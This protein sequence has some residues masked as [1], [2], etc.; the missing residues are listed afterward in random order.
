MAI[1]GSYPGLLLTRCR[2]G[3]DLPMSEMRVPRG[4]RD[5]GPSEMRQRRHLE[6]K[7][8]SGFE[9]FAYQEVQTP[10]FEHLDLFTAK[11]GQGI[12]SELYDFLDKGGRALALRPE[13]TAAVMRFYHESM[14]VEPKPIK[15]FYYGNCFRYDRPQKGRYREF[16]QMGC[17]LIGP[18]TPEAVGEVIALGV[19]LLRSAGVKDLV[20]RV[21]HLEVLNGALAVAGWPSSA[22]RAG[23]MRLIDKWDRDGVVAALD[24]AGVTAEARDWLLSLHEAHD[25]E[26]LRAICAA[27]PEGADA[28]AIERV[29]AATDALAQV[30]AS[31]VALGA[32]ESA[33]RIDALIARGLD[34][35]TGVVFEMDAPALGA[36]KQLLGGGQYDL[37]GVFGGQ[38]VPTCGFGLGFDR[39]LVAIEAEAESGTALEARHLDVFVAPIGDAAR[40]RALA[41]A[42]E[43][44]A[45][46]A[47]TEV[48]L[49]RRN[50]GKLLKA[51]AGRNA[52]FAILLG[53]KELEADAASVK[54]LASGEQASVPLAEVG[55]FVAERVS[56]DSLQ[57]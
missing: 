18:D 31:A 36:E 28:A 55:A 44:R 26:G 47:R 13:L 45:G 35:Y 14:T 6:A 46:G 38:P 24:A 9:R 2:L 49:M 5:F 20:A 11:S 12:V 3:A 7:M 54:D 25:L 33:L 37:S 21:G 4:T 1:T 48:D 56:R 30:W 41:L 52:R 39:T 57:S 22:D 43:L 19:T 29:T 10:T 34:Y 27:A 40:P 8:R 23:L 42:A 17:E 50:P 53:D 16:W 51:A 15:L 32:D